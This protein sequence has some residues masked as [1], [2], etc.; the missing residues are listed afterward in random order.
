[1]RVRVLTASTLVVILMCLSACG[2]NLSPHTAA[3]DN[4]LQTKATKENY[5]SGAAFCETYKKLTNLEVAV[6]L[7]VPKFYDHPEIGMLTIYAYT[8]KPFDPSKPSYIFVDGG[9]GQN[10]HG[11][12]GDYL[13]GDANEIRFDQR[14]LGCSAPPTWDEYTDVRLYSSLNNIRDIDEV[15][16]AYGLNKWSVYGVSYGTVPAT[17]YGSKFAEH[18]TSVVL[19][20][21]LGDTS[22]IGDPQYK[23]DKLNLVL[24]LLTAAQRVSFTTLMTEHDA[25]GRSTPDSSALKAYMFQ[26]FYSDK[27]MTKF[28]EKLNSFI[29]PDGTISRSN[30]QKLRERNEARSAE[31]SHPQQPGAVD[32]NMLTI[33]YCKDLAARHRLATWVAYRDSEFY[34]KTY[35]DERPGD[36]CDQAGVKASDETPYLI[37]DYTTAVPVYYF[38]GAYDG[39][40][41]AIG[42]IKH[43]QIVPTSKSYFMLARKGGHNPNLT[44]LE[45]ENPSIVHAERR[46]FEKA[47]LGQEITQDEI[48]ADNMAQTPDQHWELYLSPNSAGLMDGALAGID[49]FMSVLMPLKAAL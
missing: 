11:L 17:M 19:E 16:K 42:A 37:K 27:G 15:R 40:T 14:G 29:F 32:E 38:Q 41:L 46:L 8:L 3:V 18:V 26:F 7:S 23:A 44:R 35:F 4:P 12:I 31:Y 45:S 28:A 49:S 30:L 47:I 5:L 1:M 43:W 6:R 21:V 9:P 25:A 36:E 13:N 34:V 24:Q 33:I 48:N 2:A 39:A 20:G 10:T 22:V